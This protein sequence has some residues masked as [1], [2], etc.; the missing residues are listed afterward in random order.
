MTTATTDQIQMFGYLLPGLSET[1]KR[2]P[3]TPLAKNTAEDA[4]GQP[5]KK[6]KTRR[7][8]QGSRRSAPGKDLTQDVNK[9]MYLISRILI[10][11]EDSINAAKM[12]RGFTVFMAQTGPAGLLTNLYQA[13]LAWN[14]VRE[15]EPRKIT[16]P[17]RVTLLALMIAELIVRL[18]NLDNTP[19]A[20][21]LAMTEGLLDQQERLQYQKWDGESKKLLPNPTMPG[22]PIK[23]VMQILKEMEPLILEDFVLRFHAPRKI[24][25]TPETENKAVFKLEISLRHP[26]ANTLYQNMAKLADNAVWQLIGCQIRKDGVRRSNPIQELMKMISQEGL[27]P[28]AP[29]NSFSERFCKTIRTPAT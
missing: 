16:Q 4:S 12:D 19:E 5:G 3:A 21:K 7:G 1:L 11:H 8:G 27:Q 29:R 17:L 14:K 26:E 10:Q 13:S 18:Q 9:L 6:Q 22:L 25:P 2:P 28:Q 23:D 15:T 24:K 20:K